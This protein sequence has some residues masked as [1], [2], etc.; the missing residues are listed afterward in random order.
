MIGL[1]YHLFLNKEGIVKVLV[2]DIKE[3]NNEELQLFLDG[4]NEVNKE[5]DRYQQGLVA[6]MKHQKFIGGDTQM[7]T[8][9]R[10]AER[11]LNE[12]D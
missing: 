7:S 4:V 11:F 10:I 2:S 9:Y 8:T 5:R 3:L 6:I 12:N 1:T